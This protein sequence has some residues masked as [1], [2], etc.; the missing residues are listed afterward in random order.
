MKLSLDLSPELTA[1]LQATAAS[2]GMNL[3]DFVARVLQERVHDHS[4]LPQTEAELLSHINL[5]MAADFWQEYF[6]LKE[7]RK[8]GTLTDEE[9]ARLVACSDELEQANA[10]RMEY[11]L[12]LARLRGV[13]L[14]QLMLDLGIKQV[15]PYV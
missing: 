5:G 4:I 9:Q 11:L 1:R 6:G 13:S 15:N 2:A 7:K 12:A 3:D 8:Q 14:R 10:R